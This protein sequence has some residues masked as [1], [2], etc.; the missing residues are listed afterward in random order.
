[1]RSPFGIN[2][3]VHE[4]QRRAVVLAQGIELD[5]AV[6]IAVPGATDRD[7]SIIGVAVRRAANHESRGGVGAVTDV[8]RMEPLNIVGIAA[9]NFLGVWEEHR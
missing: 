3:A 9:D 7:R 6:D 2:L 4:A 8:D 1:M 5:H